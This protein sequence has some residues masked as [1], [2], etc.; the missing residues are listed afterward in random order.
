MPRT[1]K[2]GDAI[3]KGFWRYSFECI[4]IRSKIKQTVSVLYTFGTLKL[5]PYGNFYKGYSRRNVSLH[6]SNKIGNCCPAGLP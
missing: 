5:E 4:I 3:H 1:Y 2:D 6:A